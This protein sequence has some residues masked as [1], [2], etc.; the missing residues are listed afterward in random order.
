MP[1]KPVTR[2]IEITFNFW[3]LGAEKTVE[4]RD[5]RPSQPVIVRATRARYKV[6]GGRRSITAGLPLRRTIGLD[7]VGF[8][9]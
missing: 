5:K 3:M 2:S 4:H 9:K 8:E 7:L 6:S 1:I